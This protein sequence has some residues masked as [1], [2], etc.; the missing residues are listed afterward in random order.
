ME[1][2]CWTYPDSEEFKKS[3]EAQSL[4]YKLTKKVRTT[5]LS[6]DIEAM[7]ADASRPDKKVYYSKGKIRSDQDVM[8][9][10]IAAD[11]DQLKTM[12][13][14][15]LDDYKIVSKISDVKQGKML[16]SINDQFK[17]LENKKGQ[18]NSEA[19]R[20]VLDDIREQCED[21]LWETIQDIA[22]SHENDNVLILDDMHRRLDTE[23]LPLQEI[24]QHVKASYDQIS[25]EYE[26]V[27]LDAL[28]SY[29]ILKKNNLLPD[30]MHFK[31]TNEDETKLIDMLKE[32]QVAIN[33][34]DDTIAN[35]KKQVYRLEHEGQNANR[36]SISG[37]R[38]SLARGRQ[39]IRPS[40]NASF[41]EEVDENSAR[42]DIGVTSADPD[43]SQ[44]DE[45]EKK[46]LVEIEQLKAHNSRKVQ[47]LKD[48]L[49]KVTRDW[50][51]RSRS[52]A[53]LQ[54][55]TKLQKI[56]K[57][58]NILLNLATKARP[59]PDCDKE[60]TAYTSG[61]TLRQMDIHKL[62]NII[63]DQTI[64]PI[65]TQASVLETIRYT[66][67]NVDIDE[68]YVP[69]QSMNLSVLSAS[70]P[71]KRKLSLQQQKSLSFNTKMA[72]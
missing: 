38:S 20:T 1:S 14:T 44:A 45:L 58:Q 62:K 5:M 48:K 15:L 4:C 27:K 23:L 35:L 61:M 26:K 43:Y 6:A 68:S 29:L 24:Y 40:I 42:P 2:S 31:F 37:G 64:I 34:K 7:V 21:K 67:S 53:N 41:Q 66:L 19:F 22:V 60:V 28:Q 71:S 50:Q 25:M 47:T 59:R 57:R 63:T 8:T 65:E 17:H 13:K 46:Y 18:K 52:I 72:E 3:Q 10:E 30:N 56:L 33:Q 54:I 49:E 32:Y 69:P 12:R 70:K 11:F 16:E 55:N 36:G 39:S 51:I 9:D